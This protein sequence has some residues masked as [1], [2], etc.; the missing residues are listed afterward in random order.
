MIRNFLNLLEKVDKKDPMKQKIKV[1]GNAIGGPLFSNNGVDCD[2]YAVRPA[3]WI[4]L[5]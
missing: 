5:K 1:V 2:S 3:I 4:V